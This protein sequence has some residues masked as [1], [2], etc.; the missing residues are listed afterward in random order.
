MKNIGKKEFKGFFKP[1]SKKVDNSEKLFFWK[2]SDSIIEAIIKK[3]IPQNIAEDS[4]I[5]DAGGGT[6]RWIIRLSSMYKSKFI[7]YDLSEDMLIQARQNLEKTGVKSK[8]Q[9][10]QGDITDMR[11][12]KN[13][14]VDY[15]ISVY[16]P[17]SFVYQKEKAVAEMFRVL[18]KSGTMFIMGQ[19]YYNAIYSKINNYSASA[20]ELDELESEFLVKWNSYVPPLNI[21]S[22]ES[23]EDLLK[24]A[25]FGNIV[26]YGVTVFAQPG[27]EDFDLE[28]KQK[29]KISER[30]E[31]DPKFFKKVFELEMKFNGSPETVNRG[32][33]IISVAKK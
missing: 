2:L 32:M 28:N 26:S 14:S 6:G 4:V 25:G 20:K 24:E 10:I 8:V 30:L 31:N 1:Y 18:K 19:G 27:L 13:N 22:K 3:H 23:L 21:F 11:A 7:L 16:N 15:I 29:S 9:I 12:V 33:N 17:I 5:L